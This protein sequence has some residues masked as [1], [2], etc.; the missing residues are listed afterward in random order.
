[1]A[2]LWRIWSR[3]DSRWLAAPRNSQTKRGWMEKIWWVRQGK[4]ETLS[5]GQSR[6]SL[7]KVWLADVEMVFQKNS[8]KKGREDHGLARACQELPCQ[9][10]EDTKSQLN[11]QEQPGFNLQHPHHQSSKGGIYFQYPIGLSCKFCSLHDSFHLQAN[12]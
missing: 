6:S 5:F 8:A 1:M 2:F 9:V 12:G 7:K 4:N 10:Q 11:R 3:K